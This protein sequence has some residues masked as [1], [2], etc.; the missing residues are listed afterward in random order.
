MLYFKN[1]DM[2]KNIRKIEEMYE[3]SFI[4]REKFPFTVLVSASNKDGI[5]FQSIYNDEN[6]IG[7]LF[8]IQDGKILFVLY[9]LINSEYQNEGYGGQVMDMLH[10][11][12]RNYD[13]ILNIEAV[14]EGLPNSEARLKRQEFFTK[15]GLNKMNLY[16]I[17]KDMAYEIMCTNINREVN[18]KLF[19]DLLNKMLNPA[20]MIMLKLRKFKVLPY[21]PKKEVRSKW[22]NLIL[23]PKV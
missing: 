18:E 7:M 19:Y 10:E 23:R 11:K 2:D 1:V 20:L 4:E 15:H 13:I 21:I 6:L 17:D 14:Q 5:T 12:Y 8:T 22:R 16:F 9:L 3:N